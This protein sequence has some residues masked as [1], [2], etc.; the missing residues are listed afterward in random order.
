MKAQTQTTH[1]TSTRTQAAKPDVYSRV[2]DQ[3]IAALENGVRPWVQPW[4]TKEA[5]GSFTIPLRHNGIPYRGINVLLLWSAAIEQ[6]YSRNIWMTYKQAEER[7]AHVRKGEKGSLVVYANQVSKIETN[8]SGEDVENTFGFLKAYTVFNIEQIE[9]L[10]GDVTAPTEPSPALPPHPMFEQ[11]EAF[12]AQTGA[13]IH[14]GGNRAF[15]APGPDF[16]QLPHLEAF[17]DAESYIATKAHELIHWTGH[18]SRLGRSFGERFGDQAYATEELV[19]ELGA[20]FL[21]AGLGV[22]VE[23][24]P[25]HADYLAAWLSVLRADKRAIFTAAS[26][27]QR[28]A[29]FLQSLNGQ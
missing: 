26:H 27:A 1:H 8:E 25:D 20:A 29:D 16:V 14:H 24:R 22:S 4:A 2:T 23:P 6:G 21:C 18:D 17:N 19:A 28:A 12:F 11:A 9:G 3:I 5:S 13:V 15:Y 10:P 7:G